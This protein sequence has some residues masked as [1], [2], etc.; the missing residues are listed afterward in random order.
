MSQKKLNHFFAEFRRGLRSQDKQIL[1]HLIYGLNELNYI[2]KN[3][4]IEYSMEELLL[5][6]ILINEQKFQNL[7]RSNIHRY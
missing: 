5:L 2:K 7:P 4:A 1:D 6:I 3:Q